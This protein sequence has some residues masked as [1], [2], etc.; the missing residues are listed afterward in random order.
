MLGEA[1]RSV[2]HKFSAI[3]LSAQAT[4]MPAAVNQFEFNFDLNR[5]A[6]ESE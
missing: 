3:D 4:F 5:A 2:S 1:E 6:I